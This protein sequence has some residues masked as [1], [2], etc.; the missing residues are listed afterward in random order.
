MAAIEA[1][2]HSQHYDMSVR[3]WR[4]F[5]FLTQ[6]L[7]LCYL[8]YQIFVYFCFIYF[9][10]I[11]KSRELITLSLQGLKYYHNYDRFFLG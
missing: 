9:V 7:N 3:I 5:E 8:M 2:I 1:F 11:E 10:Q 4:C 6:L